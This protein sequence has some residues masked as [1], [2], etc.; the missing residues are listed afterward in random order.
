[1]ESKPKEHPLIRFRKVKNS[2]RYIDHVSKSVH[3]FCYIDKLS[4]CLYFHI[5]CSGFPVVSVLDAITQSIVGSVPTANMDYRARSPGNGYAGNVNVYVLF[6]RWADMC[7]LLCLLRELLLMF[8]LHQCT[9][10]MCVLSG[11][12]EWNHHAAEVVRRQS[13]H[14]WRQH[15]FPGEARMHAR[16]HARTH[17]IPF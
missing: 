12:R 17:R 7:T 3:F 2:K 13:W 11:V 10:S 8:L 4:F 6:A 16:P 1:M 15:E 9:S 5:N 14:I